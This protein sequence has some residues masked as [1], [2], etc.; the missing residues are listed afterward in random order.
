MRKRGKEEL[1]AIERWDPFRDAI[2]LRDAMSTLFQDS[3]VRPGALSGPNGPVSLPLDVSEAED[4]FVVRA[5]LPGIKPDDVQI[6]VH[7]DTLT[8]ENAKNVRRWG[9]SRGLGELAAEGPKADTR[10]DPTPTVTVPLRALI[11]LIDCEP[12]RW[13]T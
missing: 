4:H 2:S 11:H 6:T 9:T 8:I 1:L 3:F 10:L 7:G 5:S 12:A 13:A